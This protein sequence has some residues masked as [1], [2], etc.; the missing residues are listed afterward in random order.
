MVSYR[1]THTRAR[2]LSL[3][4]C[5]CVCAG[6]VRVRVR[7]HVSFSS[8]F[9]SPY[10][11]VRLFVSDARTHQRADSAHAHGGLLIMLYSDCRLVK[12]GNNGAP[13]VVRNQRESDHLAL[14]AEASSSSKQREDQT[15]RRPGAC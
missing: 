9:R 1:N 2:S 4:V 15:S 11:Y 14:H 6:I 12:S 7:T 5:V 3:C 8:L 10:P 13:F